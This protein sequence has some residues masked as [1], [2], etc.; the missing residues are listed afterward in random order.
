MTRHTITGV[1]SLSAG[2]VVAQPRTGRVLVIRQAEP[3]RVT[4]R[5]VESTVVSIRAYDP[6]K[7]QDVAVYAP[8]GQDWRV[9]A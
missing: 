4:Y 3:V 5:G 2:N 1:Q 9:Y 6:D 8:L 7:R